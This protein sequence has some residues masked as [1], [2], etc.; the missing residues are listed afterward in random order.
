MF[1]DVPNWPDEFERV[2]KMIPIILLLFACALFFI[3]RR[4]AG[5]WH[6]VR[7][8]L[9]SVGLIFSIGF[10]MDDLCRLNWPSITSFIN[11]NKP[12]LVVQAILQGL[13]TDSAI[14]GTIFT[15]ASIFVIAWPAKEPSGPFV[16]V[17]NEGV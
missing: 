5:G 12:G 7:S 1:A 9:G 4:R 15:L 8:V 3:A 6:M 17:N 10:M 14:L 13:Q 16:A 11:M 2:G